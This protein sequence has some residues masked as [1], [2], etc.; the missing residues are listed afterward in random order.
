[1]ETECFECSSKNIIIYENDFRCLKCGGL[2]AYK[3]DSSKL[4]E[5]EKDCIRAGVNSKYELGE[6]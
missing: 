4:T 5:H 3:K 1:M 2:F 6:I